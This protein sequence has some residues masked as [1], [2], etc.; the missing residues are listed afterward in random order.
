MSEKPTMKRSVAIV[1][2]SQEAIYFYANQNIAALAADY[3]TI[4]KQPHLKDFYCLKVDAWYD[5]D[6]VVTYL[7]G[8][9]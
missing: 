1:Q 7:E 9:G 6:E 3:G 2:K 4:E 5:Y 8:L